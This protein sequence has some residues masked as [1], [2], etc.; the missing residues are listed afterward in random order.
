MSTMVVKTEG[1]IAAPIDSQVL[2]GSVVTSDTFSGG[3]GDLLG[4]MT[5]AKL[6]GVPVQWAGFQGFSSD[7]IYRITNGT[8]EA[9]IASGTFGAV[10]FHAELADIC[11]QFKISRLDADIPGTTAFF[12]VRKA[13]DGTRTTYRLNFNGDGRLDLTF[14]DATVEGVIATT[15]VGGVKVGDTVMYIAFENSHKVYING[16]LKIDITHSGFLGSGGVSLS[17]GWF[18]APD[19][20]WGID[21]LI[22][23]SLD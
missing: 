11:V 16:A 4:R 21:D 22:I 18:D 9:V 7:N 3:D 17:R 13:T 12:D 6:G 10:G 14:R 2:T 8:A 20:T 1:I 15:G 5:D 19:I 23:Y